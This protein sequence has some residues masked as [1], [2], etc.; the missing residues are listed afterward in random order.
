MS[1]DYLFKAV[2]TVVKK[3]M[4]ALELLS[5][6]ETSAQMQAAGLADNTVDAP[7]DT[8]LVE[9]TQRTLD[10]AVEA[11][12]EILTSSQEGTQQHG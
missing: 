8:A 11:L 12:E 2:D 1:Q 3:S 6:H 10:M 4:K 7:V 9:E 5:N